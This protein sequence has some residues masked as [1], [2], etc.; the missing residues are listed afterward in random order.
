MIAEDIPYALVLEDD[1]FLKKS[2]VKMVEKSLEQIK[3][4]KPERPFIISY[5]ATCLKLVPRSQR[6]KGQV[7]YPAG[8]L[9]CM[10]AYMVNKALAKAVV[11]KTV[12]LKCGEPNDLWVDRLQREYGLYDLYWTH[13][14]TAEQGSHTGRMTTSLGNSLSE[15]HSSLLMIRIKRR[16]S[17]W[18]KHILYFFR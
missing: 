13:P 7:I 17:T 14:I 16:L 10:G 9:Q 6:K 12:E 15:R 8:M 3:Q 4:V 11:E 1:M 2:F 18:Y 5:E